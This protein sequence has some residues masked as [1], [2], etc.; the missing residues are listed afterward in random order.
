METKYFYGLTFPTMICVGRNG[1]LELI[2][3]V[4]MYQPDVIID[5]RLEGSGEDHGSI[6]TAKAFDLQW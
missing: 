1:A 3:M 6:A 5:N 2:R 4:R